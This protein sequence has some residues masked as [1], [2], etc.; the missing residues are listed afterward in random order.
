MGHN[1]VQGDLV[2]TV[3][4]GD[5]VTRRVAKWLLIGKPCCGVAWGEGFVNLLD[6]LGYVIGVLLV[7]YIM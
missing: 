7:K 3:S 6:R 1:V 4:V 5:A 2:H